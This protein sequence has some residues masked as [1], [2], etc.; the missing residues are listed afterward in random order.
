ML[1]SMVSE[2]LSTSTGSGL[3]ECINS[4]ILLDGPRRRLVTGNSWQS[5]N[6]PGF[7]M[8]L[9]T[10]LGHSEVGDNGTLLS[11]IS[12]AARFAETERVMG[13]CELWAP[14]ASADMSSSLEL[15][16]SSTT[17]GELCVTV[18]IW[19][20]R[21]TYQNLVTVSTFLPYSW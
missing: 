15:S 1:A 19:G 4:G 12:S 13:R 2:V 10:F 20:Q 8:R 16:R 6:L 3:E 5:R 21:L 11:S 18:G 17:A 7:L 14:I 9:W